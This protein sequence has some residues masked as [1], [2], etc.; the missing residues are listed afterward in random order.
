M[1]QVHWLSTSDKYR[2]DS[3]GYFWYVGR[4]DDMLK[5]SGVWVSPT[6]IEATLME[7]DFVAEVAAVGRKGKDGLIKPVAWV[8]LRENLTG[9]PELERTL[10]DFV[11]GR[12]AVYKRPKWIE[13]TSS[14]PKTAT[15][16][17]QRFTLRDNDHAMRSAAEDAVYASPSDSPDLSAK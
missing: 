9:T 17:I 3:D 7:H 10:Q 13:F 11:V 6:E 1:I 12:L 4:S 15:G 14:L 16:K 8:V 2:R 5:V